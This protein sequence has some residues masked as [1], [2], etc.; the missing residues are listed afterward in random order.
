MKH[1]H[2]IIIVVLLLTVWLST[3][4]FLHRQTV[5]PVSVKDFSTFV[6]WQK[7]P[8]DIEVI[9]QGDSEY[10][11]VMGRNGGIIP[12]GPSGYVFDRSGRLLD[13][14][15]DIGDDPRF[16]NKWIPTSQRSGSHLDIDSALRWVQYGGTAAE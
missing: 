6:M 1:F 15:S 10:L 12:S 3:E 2:T 16:R 11:F 5:P 14:S 13:W 4:L 9:H 8:R 7:S